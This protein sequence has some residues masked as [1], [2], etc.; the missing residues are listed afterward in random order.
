[1]ESLRDAAHTYRLIVTRRQASE[2]LLLADPSAWSLP[3]VEVHPRH[4]LA[5]QLTQEC[6]RVWGIEVYCLFVSR[7]G[8]ND[9]EVKAKCAFMESV[10]R[11]DEPPAEA[12]WMPPSVAMGRCHPEE[13]SAI[14]DGLTELDSYARDQTTGRFARPGW[15][16]ELFRWAQEQ[17]SSLGLRLTG[18]FRQLNASPTFSLIRLETNRGALWF[19]ATGEP[20]SH[21]LP[22]TVALGRLFPSHV[23][24]IYAVH[25]AWNG[26]LTAE[27][28]GVS[29]DQI[30]DRSK[31]ERAAEELAELQIASIGKTAELLA[32]HSK[33]LR[34]PKLMERI[35]PFLAR[36]GELMA[37]QAKPWPAPLVRSELETLAQGLKESCALL[38]SR[39][40][41]DTIGNTDCN[42]GNILE[43]GDRFVFLDWA[44]GCVANP[45]L[46]FEYL[47]EHAA[48]GRI[49][50]PAVA[51]RLAAAYLRPWAS[52]C[53]P[54]VVRQ[55]LTLSP[56]IAVL[57]HA[58]ANDAWRSAD[59][60]RNPALAG[61]LRSL[62]RRMYR[63]AISVAQR[64]EPCLS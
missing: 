46:T 49:D 31:W 35:D 58:V 63:E 42:P 64:S 51:E 59:A 20:N 30:T 29:L 34:V 7:Q 23:P 4:R 22:V 2:I 8:I 3:R 26:W 61:Y 43:S 41:P 37:A 52:C 32:A 28:E 15:L 48:R 16:P 45:L 9:P 12:H 47:R 56:L 13:A 53:P 5:E 14:R 60:A 55:A 36:M 1:M 57:A 6:A 11:N 39:G 25:D 27:V 54:N 10:R 19:K 50:K 18:T 38:A 40:L 21:E 62:T 24:R 17:V 33:D 44:E